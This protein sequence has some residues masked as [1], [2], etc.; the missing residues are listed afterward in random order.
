MRSVTLNNG[1]EMPILGF[2]TFQL[3]DSK[4]CEE[5]VANALEAGYRFIDTASSYENEVFIGRAISKSALPREELF[6]ESKMWVQDFGRGK[7]RD[8]FE[9]SCERLGVDYLDCC[10]LHQN[11]GDVYGAWRDLED[12]YDAGRIRAI[13]VSNFYP[14]RLYDLMLHNRVAPAV[15]QIEINPFCQQIESRR[16]MAEHGV[17][18][19]AWS[20]LA[21]G[22]NNIFQNP[23]LK[24]IAEKHNRSVAQVTLRWAL[25]QGL[26]AI[27]EAASKAHMLENLSLFD[28]ELDENDMATVEAMNTE[29]SV[30]FGRLA[31]RDPEVVKGLG[32]LIFN[33]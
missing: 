4:E 21:T 31:H 27:P 1:I 2:G 20:T 10:L 25:Q 14:D 8:A 11:F 24:A 18:A 16:F 29:T 33:T 6:I 19:Q 7:T 26:V 3:N 17:Q 13:G 23:G 28:F 9:R 32:T 15:N 30:Y 22:R 12:L 5:A